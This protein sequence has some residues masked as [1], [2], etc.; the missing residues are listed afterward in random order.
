MKQPGLRG[1]PRIAFN[2]IEGFS[3]GS[4]VST[5]MVKEFIDYLDVEDVLPMLACLSGSMTQGLS[6]I[7][8]MKVK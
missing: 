3:P 6:V 2:L 5:S 8:E 4:A 7:S 1:K